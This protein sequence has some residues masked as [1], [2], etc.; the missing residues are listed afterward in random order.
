MLNRCNY[1]FIYSIVICFLFISQSANS[2]TAIWIEDFDDGGGGRWT[3]E[4]A[5]G[6][7]TNPTPLGIVSLVYG[8]NAAVAHDNFV[9]NARNTPELDADIVVG[10]TMS[11]QGQFVR[12]RHYACSAKSFC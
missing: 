2:Q 6:S 10:T 9:I 12:G 8:V 7:L 5:L 4:N 3:M 1:N 11:N